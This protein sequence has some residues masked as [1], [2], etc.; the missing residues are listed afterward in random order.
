MSV[1]TKR[2]E[3]IYLICE[4]RCILKADHEFDMI[5]H[6]CGHTIEEHQTMHKK[7]RLKLENTFRIEDL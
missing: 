3:Y 2:C 4:G 7:F 6:S 1:K 5:P